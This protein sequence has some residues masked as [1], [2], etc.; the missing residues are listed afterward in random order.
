MEKWV[1]LI[2]HYRE[3]H[4]IAKKVRKNKSGDLSK[5][6]CEHSKTS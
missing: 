4:Q 5:G 2:V 3:Q 6:S 1:A